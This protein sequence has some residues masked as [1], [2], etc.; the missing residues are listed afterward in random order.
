MGVEADIKKPTSTLFEK[1]Q[2]ETEIQ[3]QKE[4]N[5]K[6]KKT[7]KHDLLEEFQYSKGG[8]FSQATVIEVTAP[9]NP[10]F[11]EGLQFLDS[12]YNR[13]EL[14]SLKSIAGI[15]KDLEKLTEEQKDRAKEQDNA[16]TEDEQ[17]INSYNQLLSGLEQA[18]IKQLNVCIAELLAKSAIIN[19]EDKF[20][21][22]MFN[23]LSI[24][25]RRL[26]IGKY[27]QNFTST[28][29]RNSKNG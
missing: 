2:T 1:T 24:E 8:N 4:E 9:K 27:L 12:L 23:E 3:K 19:G 20:E 11:Y 6:M 15:V 13:A 7:F 16:L 25:D 26:L 10:D 5:R 21:A 18:E 29:Q 17:A 14:K 22:V 28:A